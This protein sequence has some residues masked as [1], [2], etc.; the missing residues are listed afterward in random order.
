MALEPGRDRRNHRREEAA[1]RDADEEPIGE[2][3][4][5]QARGAACQGEPQSQQYCAGQDDDARAEAVAERPP[6]EA[7]NPHG[8]EI[9][10]HRARYAGARPARILGHRLQEHRKRKHRADRDAGHEGA[11]RHHDPPVA[12]PRCH[13]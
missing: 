5:E 4:L 1:R 7:R 13:A 11:Q 6:P 10:R 12:N 2:L 8:E 3:E 9:E